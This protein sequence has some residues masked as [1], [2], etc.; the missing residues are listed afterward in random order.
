MAKVKVSEKSVKK[1]VMATRSKNYRMAWKVF[2]QGMHIWNTRALYLY[3]FKSYG[4]G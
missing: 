4:Q 1:K 2:L 3:W